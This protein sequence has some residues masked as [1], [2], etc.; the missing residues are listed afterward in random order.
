MYLPLY[1]PI[2]PYIS[3]YLHI[4]PYISLY[5]SPLEVQEMTAKLDLANEHLELDRQ[6]KMRMKSEQK[7]AVSCA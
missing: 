6:V 4:S 3:L 5:L 1:L 7:S 2:S